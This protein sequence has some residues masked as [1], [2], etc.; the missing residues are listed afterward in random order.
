MKYVVFV[1]YHVMHASIQ[2]STDIISKQDQ[3]Y[4]QEGT[5]EN[6]RMI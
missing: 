4:K 2:K 1:G 3:K 6:Q 5:E